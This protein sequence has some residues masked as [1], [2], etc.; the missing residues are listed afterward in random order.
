[1]QADRTGDPGQGDGQ[2]HFKKTCRHREKRDA[3]TGQQVVPTHIVESLAGHRQGQKAEDS[4]F[5][6]IE[7]TGNIKG[8]RDHKQSNGEVHQVGVDRQ[9][10]GQAIGSQFRS[11]LLDRR[12]TGEELKTHQMKTHQTRPARMASTT[13]TVWSPYT[14]I[15]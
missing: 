14:Q 9:A 7:G 12:L 10:V 1:M 2:Q 15:S 5:Q 4:L 13:F 8:N 11:K 6:G 3:A